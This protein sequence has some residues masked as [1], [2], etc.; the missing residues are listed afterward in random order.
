MIG[1]FGHFNV[2]KLN[3][4]LVLDQNTR[5]S[6]MEGFIECYS[7]EIVKKELDIQ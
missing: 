1:V 6:A 5:I 4:R 7:F 3:A 2:F